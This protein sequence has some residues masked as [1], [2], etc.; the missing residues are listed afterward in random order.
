MCSSGREKVFVLIPGKGMRLVVPRMGI[1]LLEFVWGKMP[2]PEIWNRGPRYGVVPCFHREAGARRPWP[3]AILSLPLR[4][5]PRH[6]DLSII[7]ESK[8]HPGVG[9]PAKGAVCMV[10]IH[11]LQLGDLPA[12]LTLGP[13]ELPLLLRSEPTPCLL[14]TSDAADDQGLV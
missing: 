2:Y 6:H 4:S 10:Q 13:H 1:S 12:S 9:A 5:S 14:Y 3:V 7:I 11:N 8:D